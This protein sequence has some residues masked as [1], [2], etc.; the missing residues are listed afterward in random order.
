MGKF[1]VDPSG[2]YPD[3]ACWSG[4][5]RLPLGS[6]FSVI[7]FVVGLG[8][9]QS[10][11]AE[12]PLE[13]F[14]I[15]DLNAVGAEITWE[16]KDAVDAGRVSKNPARDHS[17]RRQRSRLDRTAVPRDADQR[18]R[19]DVER[20]DRSLRVSR[21]FA[22]GVFKMSGGVEQCVPMT[23]AGSA[24]VQCFQGPKRRTR[25]VKV[26]EYRYGSNPNRPCGITAI[27]VNDLNNRG[28]GATLPT[29]NCR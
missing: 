10:A 27:S 18:G 8:L 14:E 21:Q 13:I 3:Q 17:Q 5:C 23:M 29:S 12:T 26:P 4:H 7:L 6:W 25:I 28:R 20:S 2:F 22:D 9:L 19:R 1:F 15:V 16:D 24:V 11:A